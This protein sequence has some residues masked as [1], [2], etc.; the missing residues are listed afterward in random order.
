MK[1]LKVK[2]QTDPKL[3]VSMMTK[4][5]NIEKECEKYEYPN[6]INILRSYIIKYINL[7]FG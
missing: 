6:E 5:K 7:R 3:F 2:E 1:I 4:L